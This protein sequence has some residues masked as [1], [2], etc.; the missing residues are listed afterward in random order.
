MKRSRFTESQIVE[1]LKEEDAGLPAREVWRK[2]GI[3]SATSYYLWTA[4]PVARRIEFSNRRDRLQ[5]S[6]RRTHRS[7]SLVTMS[8]N[9][10]LLNRPIL[11][12]RW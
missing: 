4:L 2:H 11:S 6:M 1:I 3:S 12:Y 7:S 8:S 9:P 10:S 5:T